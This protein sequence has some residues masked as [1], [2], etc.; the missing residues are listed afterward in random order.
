M[1]D[2]LLGKVVVAFTDLGLIHLGDLR[3]SQIV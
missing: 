2:M 3:L 1:F